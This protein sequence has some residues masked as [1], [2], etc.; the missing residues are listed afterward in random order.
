MKIFK[1]IL[2]A[3]AVIIVIVIIAALVIVSG[4]KKSALPEYD[5]Q[6]TI[7]GLNGEVTVYRD[8]RGMPH[9]YAAD[10]HDLYFATGYIMAQERLWQMDLIRRATTGRLS[11]IFGDDYIRTDL[12]L[13]SLDMTT[14]SKMVLSNQAPEIT[15]CLQA[16]ADGVNKYISDAG[17]K[18]PPEFRILSYKP[19]EWKLE[20]IANI[21]GYMGWDL[22][23]G[24]LSADIFIYRLINKMGEE[25]AGQLIP[26]W[27]T[28]ASPVFPEFRLEEESLREALSFISALDK[29]QALGIHSFSGSN[30]WAVSGARSTTGKPLFSNDMH[31]GLNSPGIWMQMHQVIPGKFNV[32][33]VVV[34]GEPF[35]VAGHNEKIAWGMTNLMVDDVDLFA[36]KINP[37]NENQYFFNGEWRNLMVRKEIIRSKTGRIDTLLLK[38]THRGPVISDLRDIK[39]AVLTMRWSGYDPSDELKAVYSLNRAAGWEEFRESLES[40]S[41]I[42]Q[43]FAYAD[44]N[45]NIGLVTGG[46]IP[47]RKGY[48]STI[49]SGET[50]EFDWKGYV[51]ASQL[52][53]SFN[54]ES[55]FISSANNKTVSDEYPYYISFRFYVP[56]RIDRIRQMIGEKEKLGIDDFKRM[57]TDQHSDYA[58]LLTPFILRIKDRIP[59]MNP[60][61]T[62]A[63]KILQEWD[64]NMSA[65]KIA[66]TIFEFFT[67]SFAKNLLGDD[68][69]ELY[70]QLPGS[71][72][73]YYIYRIL[74][75]GSDQFVDDI[76]TSV[77]ETLDDII[78]RSFRDEIKTLSESYGDDTGNWIW[79]NIHKFELVHPLGT[80]KI[81]DRIFN[82][83]SDSYG[84][85]GSNHTVCP[86]TY[87][88]DF[89]VT[90][91]ASERHIY[92]TADWDDSYTVI[93]TGAS[94]IPANE[95]YLSQTRTYIEGGFYRD[96]F[97]ENAVKAAAKY[98]LILRPS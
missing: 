86:Y 71:I 9:I 63:F 69:N 15:T 59:E 93:P 22:A 37:E 92:N 4:I 79:G 32:T 87:G 80:V 6:M 41:S 11:E 61:E 78:F 91:G 67:I 30:N 28:P 20:D 42:S 26:D 38:F 76:T 13:R 96:A 14:K 70:N 82:F 29:L 3:L 74:V 68:L 58:A 45:G 49:R 23:A 47:V 84:A 39:D 83:N 35:I 7:N 88:E 36:E 62:R 48:G 16:Y 12:F 31:L 34:P 40:F 8:E 25:K 77:T 64:Y 27:I 19:D 56:Y 98:K 66:P 1:S 95:F 85:G 94:G 65:D 50:D 18:L 10:E 5:G 81:L 55:G 73:D 54:P 57:V 72:K 17:R 46:G 33:G 51:P 89:K 2:I 75:T 60:A 43:N 24:N 44:I 21:I 97:S 90:D 52:P 53:F